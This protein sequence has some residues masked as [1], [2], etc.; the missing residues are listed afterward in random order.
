MLRVEALTAGY[1]RTRILQGVTLHVPRG[2]LVAL[3]GGNGTGK[4]TTLKAIAGLLVPDG[5][6]VVLDGTPIQGV[7]AETLP[8]R[9]LV[10]VP[11]GKEVFATMAVEENL[12]MGA[13]HRR[14]LRAEVVADLE[15]AYQRF[16]HLKERRRNA[17]ASLSGGERQMLAIARALMARPSMLLMDEPSA[18]LAPKVVDEISDCIAALRD[19]GLTILLVEQNVAMALD[20]AD[21]LY[22][23]RGGRIVL[24]RPVAGDVDMTELQRLYLGSEG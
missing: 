6:R 4:S 3:L 18:A 19:E 22:V 12:L 21:H 15:A 1:G 8:A 9:G 10:L 5:G 14:R 13:Y 16:P 7:P 24:D 23:I 17:A 11:Q 2:K 20:L